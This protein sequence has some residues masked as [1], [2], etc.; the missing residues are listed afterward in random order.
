MPIY[1]FTHHEA[2]YNQLALDELKHLL[3]LVSL[4]DGLA[5]DCLTHL[6]LTF[7]AEPL[8]DPLPQSEDGILRSALAEERESQQLF[9]DLAEGVER[10]ELLRAFDESCRWAA[11]LGCSTIMSPV[12]PGQ[13]A[14]EGGS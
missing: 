13:G 12:D 3:S 2:L 8:P 6:D 14:V 9:V 1:A 5:D 11:A 10:A 7:P 4:L